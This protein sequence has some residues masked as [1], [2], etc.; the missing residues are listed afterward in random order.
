MTSYTKLACPVR[1]AHSTNSRFSASNFTRTWVPDAQ[2]K[3]STL[4]ITYCARF[5]WFC[6][7]LKQ[8]L[9]QINLVAAAR[10]WMPR[11]NEN[12]YGKSL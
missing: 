7:H 9:F 11:T 4:A 2:S 3:P 5:M 10:E 6:F 1:P 12:N 8:E